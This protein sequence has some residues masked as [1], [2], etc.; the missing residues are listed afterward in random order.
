MTRTMKDRIRKVV[1]ESISLDAIEQALDDVAV[2]AQV[3][4][5]QNILITRGGRVYKVF[6]EVQL[7]EE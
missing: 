4:K 1:L 5:D 6:L 2:E 7:Q 3:S